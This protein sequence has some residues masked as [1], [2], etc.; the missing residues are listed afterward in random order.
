MDV[1][2]IITAAG[3]GSRFGQGLPKQFSLLGTESILKH[4]VRNFENCDFVS[5]VVIVLPP[6]HPSVKDISFPKVKHLAA[7]KKTRAE[8][9][10]EGLKVICQSD[11]SN[12]TVVLVHDGVRPFVSKPVIEEVAAGALDHGAA[13][14]AVKMTD[15][16]KKVDSDGFIS[17][18]IDREHLWKAATP[19]GFRIDI[20]VESYKRAI[21]LGYLESATDEAFLAEKAGFPVYVVEGNP[22]NIK[23][24][25]QADKL[26][27][28]TMLR[29]SNE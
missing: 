29:M 3:S 11:Y 8:S 6:D 27:A 15:T 28:E 17:A 2:V 16:I 12:E 14:A 9:V 25:T 21:E 24:T 1:R 4:T 5:E 19:Q 13:I 7:G 26:V 20:L 23:I 18:T 10:Y 22:E